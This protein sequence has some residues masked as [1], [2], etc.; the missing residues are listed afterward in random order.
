MKTVVF[1]YHNMGI[2]GLDALKRKGFD[3]RA[4]FSHEDNPDE[5][6][7]FDSV[8][9]WAGKNSVPAFCP[10]DVNTADWVKR[11]AAMAPDVIF[12]FYYRN[13]LGGK[14]L[15]IPP[16]GAY[17]LHGSLLP[18]YRGR[19]PVNWVLLN[20]E[21]ST[22]VTLHHMVE[23][24]DAGD[25]A[26]QK[27]ISIDV[28]DT[29]FILYSKLCNCARELLEELLPMIKDGS[30]PRIPQDLQSGSYFGGRNPEDGIIDWNWPVMRIYNLIR[31]VTKPYPGAFTYLSEGEKLLIWWGYPEYDNRS[32]STAGAIE[33]E[34]K[35][36]YIR[37]SNG[38]LQLLDIEV[39]NEE[40]KNHQ[41]F[42]YFKGRKEGLV[43][44]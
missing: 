24:A 29:A 37:A 20:G 25:I 36:V 12:S 35:N 7:W 15:N 17:N 2:V 43:V 14:I 11:I 8:V 40:M 30:A 28:K 44:K 4:V 13:L 3:I 21:E 10:E 42:E 22:G 18:A 27:K 31:A 26:G 34:E 1:A 6:C 32:D 23:K 19:C 41:I 38:R 16:S 33:V 5:N 9:E 39:I